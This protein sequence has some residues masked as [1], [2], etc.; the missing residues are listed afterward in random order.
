M[1]GSI[2][3]NNFYAFMWMSASQGIFQCKLM[4]NYTFKINIKSRSECRRKIILA[5]KIL[6][7]SLN[8]LENLKFLNIKIKNLK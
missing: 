6:K 8:I 1:N 2:N 3:W 4:L 7:S 5:Q